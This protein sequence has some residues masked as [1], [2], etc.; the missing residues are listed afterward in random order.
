MKFN[1]RSVTTNIVVISVFA[2][3]AKHIYSVALDAGNPWPIALVHAV[4]V[5]GLILLG[6]DALKDTRF[7]GIVTITYG[8]TVSLVFNAASYGAFPMPPMALAVTMPL[9]LVLSYV[10]IHASRPRTGQDTGHGTGQD[11]ASRTELDVHVRRERVSRPASRPVQAAVSQDI[12]SRPVQ[13]MSRP[14]VLGEVVPRP[15]I[16][17]VSRP[18][19]W[20]GEARR[21]IEA[22]GKGDREIAREVFGPEADDAARKRVERLRKIVTGTH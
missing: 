20:M 4:G 13:D 21:L 3:S 6:I 12:V 16:E 19:A 14:A 1:R 8:A 9:A 11:T 15:A 7:W 22:G 17:R 10:T 18:A 2:A 5:D